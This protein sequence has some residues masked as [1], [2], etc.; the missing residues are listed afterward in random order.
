[1]SPFRPSFLH[2]PAVHLAIDRFFTPLFSASSELLFSQLFCFHNY[3]RCPLVFSNHAPRERPAPASSPKSFIYRFY[4]KSRS[5]PFIYR[6]YANTPGCG[7]GCTV[8]AHYS[9]LPL[10]FLCFHKLTNPLEGNPF[11]FT[12]IQNP[13]GVVGPFA[14]PCLRA[15]ACPLRRVANPIEVKRS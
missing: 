4:V 2:P 12:S 14:A 13:R 3:L 15:S 1:M 9:L 5:N 8:T 10:R 7:G 6:I 11:V